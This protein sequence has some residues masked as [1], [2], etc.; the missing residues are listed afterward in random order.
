MVTKT[1]SHYNILSRIGSGG[2]GDVYLAEDTTLRRKVALKLLPA[3]LTGDKDRMLRFKQEA[4]AVSALN[5]PNIVTIH[6]FGEANGHNFIVTEF[7]E[8]TTL[9]SELSSSRID[10]GNAVDIALQVASALAAA[11]AKGIVHRDIKPENIMVRNDGYV[12]VLDFGLAKLTEQRV[13]DKEKSTLAD[14][15]PGVVMGTVQYMSPEQARGQEVDARSD[16]WSLGA[17]LYEA[18]SSRPAHEGESAADVIASILEREPVPLRQYA[19]RVP[20]ELEQIVFRCLKKD[21]EQRYQTANEVVTALKKLKSHVDSRAAATTVV[22]DSWVHRKVWNWKRV[23]ALIGIVG[24]IVIAALAFVLTST[25]LRVPTQ[26]GIKSLAVLPLENLSGDP[27]QD[28]LA[29]GITE[30]LINDLA[31][32][33]SLRMISR[34]TS[35]RYKK[36]DKS[37]PEIAR[38]LNVDGFVEGSIS[39]SSDSVHVRVQLVQAFPEERELW[40]GTFDKSLRDVMGL[41]GAVASNIA[42]Q[43]RIKLAPN[44]ETQLAQTRSVNPEAY[45][46]YLKGMFYLNQATPDGTQ[47]GLELLNEAISKDPANPLPY[48]YL[49][50]G[51]ATLGHGPSPP[52][53]AFERAREAALKAL[54]LDDNVAEAHLVLAELAMYDDDRWDWPSAERDLTRAIELNPT[55]GPAY[56]HYGWYL[57]LFDR[58]E[59]GFTAMRHAQEVDPLAPLWPAWQGSMNWWSG[60]N[61]EAIKEC[62]KSLG[63]NPKFPVAWS[64]LGRAYSD[65]GMH[66]E[67]IAA[68]EKAV[69]GNSSYLWSLAY[70]YARAGR[71]GDALKAAAEFQLSQGDSYELSIVYGA[72]GDKEEAI[73]SL[74]KAY[75]A[76]K[77]SAWVRNL[78]ALAFLRDDARFQDLLRRMKLPG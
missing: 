24:V 14:T 62:Q 59:E 64:V 27:G 20:E 60:R 19:P 43:I 31:K 12:K 74:Q 3:H 7:I 22:F 42:H 26:P 76:G 65:T 50:Q 2:M 54:Q 44:E 6:E 5:H 53:D 9:R 70:A 72:L 8:G 77:I 66:D 11:H 30:E 46:A 16:I 69:A 55:L 13:I 1:L 78:H 36:T 17:L 23:T 25:R 63:L 47:K 40:T 29:D 45:E 4:R 32:I 21:R 28:Y 39:Q 51:Y 67:A 52:A 15:K 18:L 35:M 10:V 57:V 49:A 68:Q 34:T 56:A 37:I 73:R 61:D 38:E 58:W 41:H 71:R 48:A 33:G 75:D